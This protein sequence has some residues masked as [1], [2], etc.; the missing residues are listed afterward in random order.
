[1]TYNFTN[2]FMWKDGNWGA[3]YPNVKRGVEV[4]S[5]GSLCAMIVDGCASS[6]TAT[7]GTDNKTRFAFLRST[8]GG[9]SWAGIATY[10]PSTTAGPGNSSTG[11]GAVASFTL[12]KNDN[13]H[14]CFRND[15]STVDT[16]RY[17]K[18]TVTKGTPWT[19]TPGTSVLC[20]TMIG[21][22]TIIR[23]DIACDPNNNPH[24]ALEWAAD[25]SYWIGL[26]NRGEVRLYNALSGSWAN[27]WSLILHTDQGVNYLAQDL[28]LAIDPALSGTNIKMALAFNHSGA[29]WDWSPDIALV[30][31]SSTGTATPAAGDW[32]TT[33]AVNPDAGGG[34]RSV[35]VA[36]AATNVIVFGGVSG[37]NAQQFWVTT[38]DN[39][40]NTLAN[41]TKL[42]TDQPIYSSGSNFLHWAQSF[43]YISSLRKMVFWYVGKTSRA[44]V[45]GVYAT[46]SSDYKKITFD[47]GD[48]RIYNP[49]NDGYQKFG[50]ISGANRISSFVRPVGYY[51]EG[52]GSVSSSTNHNIYVT[53][54]DAPFAPKPTL[55][56]PNP[57]AI[58]TTD[59]PTV[60]VGVSS[61][62]DYP[63]TSLSVVWQI[64]SDPS[65]PATAA[66]RTIGPDD[67]G[68]V[69]IG[70][71]TLGTQVTWFYATL[72]E[73]TAASLVQGTWYVRAQFVD[74]F[75]QASAW[76]AANT[77][78]VTHPPQAD[79]LGP[80]NGI[81][82]DYQGT[83]T[84]NLI[85]EFEDTSPIDAQTAFEIEVYAP[86]VQTPVVSSGLV[87]STA[88]TYTVTIPAD[89][90]DSLLSWHIRLYDRDNVAGPWSSM[91]TFIVS[92]APT[93]TFVNPTEGEQINTAS[94]I[95]QWT[96]N[97]TG[98]RVQ[99]A[100]RVTVSSDVDSDFDSG[101]ISSANNNY[102]KP[103]AWLRNNGNYTLT[104]QVRDS[105]GLLAS[106]TVH[107]T[108]QWIPPDPP[109]IFIDPIYLNLDNLG[110]VV[111]KVRPPDPG[112]VPGSVA[113]VQDDF[114]SG[115]LNTTLWGRSGGVTVASGR[116]VLPQGSSYVLLA[117]GIR[118][119][120][121]NS[122]SAAQITAGQFTGTYE[123]TM[124]WNIDSSNSIRFDI[125]NGK[126]HFQIKKAGS[127]TEAVP[128]VT[129]DAVSHAWL[130]LHETDGVILF[131]TSSNGSDWTLQASYSH[132]LD[133]SAVY[134]QFS[135]GYYGTE[136]GST[137]YVDNVNSIGSL[138]AGA[139]SIDPSFIEW[140]LYRRSVSL[141]EDWTLVDSST[142]TVIDDGGYIL[143]FEDWYVRAN[144]DYEYAAVQV[145]DRF[146]SDV[147]SQYATVEATF[148]S[149]AYWLLNQDVATSLRLYSVTGDTFKDEYEEDQQIVPGRGRYIEYGE[150]L[151]YSGSLDAQVRMIPDQPYD[152]SWPR[153]QRLNLEKLKSYRVPF[154][155]RNPFGDLFVV[156]VGDLNFTRVAGVGVTEF[157]D[158]S[159]DYAEVAE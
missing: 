84:V 108:T 44:V 143:A 47:D 8:D 68:I 27:K 129:Y 54:V 96:M 148:A 31:M 60:A 125:T 147:E 141:G 119:D 123:T 85:W 5:D 91:A 51:V 37:I 99:A 50:V 7:G 78:T 98:S 26:N 77:F 132:G 142:S 65:F 74:E 72:S 16:L 117:T 34:R 22:Q 15:E 107:F 89:Y 58:V 79:R 75:G 102:V 19:F 122:V 115:S 43:Q 146:G 130:R 92:D 121:R 17:V 138:P 106:A 149:T 63:P 13:I 36:Y 103:G 6:S 10:V 40:G 57:S 12:D 20:D 154:W 131:E 52:N 23:L 144:T 25:S 39:S 38:M 135:A 83:G 33:H 82:L 28:C 56:Q 59:L 128:A 76:S 156:G 104:L 137:S 114:S 111:V 140:R 45:H 109:I 70:T 4:F 139:S 118:Y 87:T 93:I 86:S 152:Q 151:G 90:K 110:I 113:T 120:A 35:F 145:A 69:P 80:A 21:V 157:I 71:A 126:L 64:S 94:P 81:T 101:W 153:T 127:T 53:K 112:S 134:L 66:T 62:T 18:I 11:F 159:V 42:N 46:L 97:A 95:V 48:R 32:S 136:T 29:S 73:V 30:T 24:I 2:T 116:A 1:M 150:H 3:N 124:E 158:V 100:Y 61:D 105:A 155:L 49:Y 9:V 133:L 41:L 88:K 55:V 14:L 67:T